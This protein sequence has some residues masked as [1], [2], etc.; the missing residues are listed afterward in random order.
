MP[1]PSGF[2]NMTATPARLRRTPGL[3]ALPFLLTLVGVTT[4]HAGAVLD[5]TA[6]LRYHLTARP[7]QP[8]EIPRDAYLDAVEAL[9]RFMLRYQDAEG[10]IVD[11]LLEREHQYATPYFAFAAA[12]LVHAGRAE[13]LLEPATKAVDHA[14]SCLAGGSA[15]IPDRHGEFFLSPLTEA[16]ALFDGHVSDEKLEQ[17]RAR[18]RTPIDV[19]LE[20]LHERT[21]NWRAYA[22]KGEW[23]RH[24]AGLVGRED[25]VAFV[26]DAWL[27]RTQR[28]RILPDPW[29]LYQDWSSHPQSHAVEAVG[30]GNLLA[31]TAAGYDGPSAGEIRRAAEAGTGTAL[32]LQ[33]P[34]GQCPPNGRT[35]NH[36]FN[37]VLYQLAFDVMAEEDAERG[38]LWRAGQFRRAALLSFSSINKWRRTD[39]PWR[40]MYSITKNAFT[41]QERVGYQPASNIANYSGAVMYHLAEAWQQRTTDI[42]EQPAPAEIGGYA[43]AMGPRFATVAINA[44]GMQ[45]FANLEG[46]TVPKYGKYWTP[47]GVVRMARADWDSRLGPSDGIYDAKSR[48]GVSFGPTWKAPL[49]WVR[50]AEQARDYRGTFTVRFVHPLLVRCSILYHTVTGRGGPCFRLDL[51]VTPDGVFAALRSSGTA[52]FGLTLPLL[53]NDGR[54]LDR[55]VTA[56]CASVGYPEALGNGDTQNYIALDKDA[57]LEHDGAPVLSTYGWLQALRL[58]PPGDTLHVFIYPRN[59]GDPS[60]EEIRRSFRITKTGFVSC[61]ATVEGTRYI[62]RT[63][64]G[65]YGDRLAPDKDG[66]PEVVF[67]KPCGHIAQL[68]DGRVTA[69]ECDRPVVA[70]VRRKR[71]V[72]SAYTPIRF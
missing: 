68:T 49:A 39:P 62:G 15:A 47:L 55:R 29:G 63:A 36:V 17:W 32:L 58:R 11:P 7:W 51:T 14:T 40:G 30:R 48:R 12:T 13:D 56:T 70:K 69:L 24:R 1:P 18:L 71:V 67:D 54:S 22:M 53:V 61:V 35:D 26:E 3:S 10:A 65:G 23:L 20:N 66:Q 46:D 6:V 52:D 72:L 57:S 21:N 37:D 5:E 42:D 43:V 31:L 16:L 19:V 9:C 38:L 2:A 28:E 59:E 64:A 45:I 41:P 25:A 50:L 60:A 27:R 44:G 8:L 33:D 34:T 4:S